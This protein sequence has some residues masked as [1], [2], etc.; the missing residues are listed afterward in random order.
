MSQALHAARGLLGPQVSPC[1]GT[2]LGRGSGME[3]GGGD[4]PLGCVGGE[5]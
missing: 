1:A 3:E 2:E 5:V 4:E